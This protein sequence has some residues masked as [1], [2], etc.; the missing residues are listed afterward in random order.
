LT[1]APS[2]IVRVVL[3]SHRSLVGLEKTLLCLL[4]F[5]MIGLSFFQVVLRNFFDFG[6]V[7]IN[8]VLRA[9][10]VWLVFIGAALAA[11]QQR[12][13]R[14][15]LVSR[16][17]KH[18]VVI[19]RLTDVFAD[20][21]CAAASILLFWAAVQYIV[22]TRPFSPETVFF[23]APEWMLRLVIPYAFAAMAIRSAAFVVTGLRRLK[24]ETAVQ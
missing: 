22:L 17:L 18:R 10:V 2:R 1:L 5:S 9:Q 24:R 3:F 6:F 20:L 21:F 7:W 14:I 4:L 19:R 23:G 8:E 15:D 16:L 12:H 11:D 13:L